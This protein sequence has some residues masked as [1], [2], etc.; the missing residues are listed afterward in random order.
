MNTIVQYPQTSWLK[1]HANRHADSVRLS[2]HLT[3]PACTTCMTRPSVPVRGGPW[4]LTVYKILQD[5]VSDSQT[6]IPP[7]PADCI[8]Q[9]LFRIQHVPVIH[10][11]DSLRGYCSVG[12]SAFVH[13]C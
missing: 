10:R 13:H 2:E 11:E 9:G 8:P 6:T 3:Q 4:L 1:Q 12:R 5:K 7:S